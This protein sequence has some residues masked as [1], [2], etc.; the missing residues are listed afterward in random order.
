MTKDNGG[1]QFSF[2]RQGKT[3]LS[4]RLKDLY[5]PDIW[6]TRDP[7]SH[8]LALQYSDGGG[9]GGW[10]VRVF[11]VGADDAVIDISNALDGAIRDFRSRHYCKARGNNY[12]ALKWI[13]GDLLLFAEVYPTGDCGPDLGHIEGYLVSVSDG[14]IKEHLTLDQL[15]KYPGVCLQNETD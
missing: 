13:K 9:L 12:Q 10:H 1:A 8:T 11:Q 7:D 4:F 2:A 3:A 14:T 5:N 6:I 15:R